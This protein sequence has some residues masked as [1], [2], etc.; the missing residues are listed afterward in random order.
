MGVKIVGGAF[1][2]P[3]YRSFNMAERHSCPSHFNTLGKQILRPLVGEILSLE[4]EEGNNQDKFAVSLLKDATVVGH[5]SGEFSRVFWYFLRHGG[6]ITCKDTGPTNR[7]KGL[8][9]PI[10]FVLRTTS[11]RFLDT[12]KVCE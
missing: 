2:A 11:L 8:E 3:L 9:L 10:L 5:V 4:R 1:A 7:V 6:T 12:F